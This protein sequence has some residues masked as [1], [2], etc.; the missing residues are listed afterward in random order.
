MRKITY[1]NA[2]KVGLRDRG[3]L[4]VGNF[5]DITVFDPQT[6]ADRSTYTAPFQYPV[7]IEYVLVNGKVVLEKGKH[8]G[9][10][11]GQ[12]LVRGK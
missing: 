3:Q 6:V 1:L 2:R 9:A 12:A 8:T 7:G 4:R 10:K 5:A 11:P